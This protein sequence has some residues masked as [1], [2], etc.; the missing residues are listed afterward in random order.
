MPANSI[1]R[2]SR[3]VRA[4][5]IFAV[6][7]APLLVCEETLLAADTAK[8]DKYGGLLSVKWKATGFFRTH[9]DGEKWWLVTPDGHPFL[10]IGVC[11]V[12]DRGLKARGLGYAPYRR[13]IERL[14][15]TFEKWREVTRRRLISWG[16]NSLGGWSKKEVGLPWTR[17][18]SFAGA[19]WLKGSLP[20]FFSA[21]FINRAKQYAR[22]VAVPDDK[23]LIGYFLDN[24]MQWDTDWRLGRSLF[25]V[26]VALPPEAEGKAA[27]VE[28]F[29]ERYGSPEKFNAVWHPNI[30]RWEDLADVR[31]LFPVHGAEG[32]AR[33]D[34]ELFTLKAARQYFR[35]CTT[36]LREV[37]PNHLI[38]GCRFVSWTTPEAVVK[39]C[40][41]FCDVVSIN[42]Y[43]LG[44]LGR[45]TFFVKSLATVKITP[46]EPDF[47]SF[48][49]VAGKP[50]LISEFSFRADDSGL[51]NS[52]PP[53]I[54]AQPTVPTQ[55][56]RGRK[57]SDYV[58]TWAKTNYIVGYH[59]FRYEDD[60]KEGRTLDGEDGNYGLVTI[61][62]KP[63]EEFIKAVTAA[64]STFWRLRMKGQGLPAH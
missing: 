19:H 11:A 46:C 61:E 17:T 58:L 55:R 60:P 33:L 51:P 23:M 42:F 13:T 35:V 5:M 38:L 24:E 41:E 3:C 32:R 27:L 28:F 40:G 37:D 56:D 54:F 44:P 39:A 15:G 31:E 12:Q 50:L 9:F 34:R 30:K 64:N 43:E 2:R 6:C 1:F 25:D 21:K 26:Y 48:Y 53:P 18:L 62:D 8:T 63:Y 16:F 47:R 52:F 14:Y 29:K 49:R 20:D 22:K 45:L 59:W 10:S 7:L 36:A 4:A 57:Y